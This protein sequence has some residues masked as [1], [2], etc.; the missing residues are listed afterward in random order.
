MP[1]SPIGCQ[2][3]PACTGMVRCAT[4]P[5]ASPASPSARSRPARTTSTSSPCRVPARTG[6][7]RT[8]RRSSTGACTRRSSSTDPR[9]PLAYDDEWT[10]VL[11][12]WLDGVAGS[13]DEVLAELRQG[14]AQMMAE[15]GH[16][17]MGARSA[18]FW[19]SERSTCTDLFTMSNSTMLG[20]TFVHCVLAVSHIAF[21][22][23]RRRFHRRLRSR[24]GARDQPRSGRGP[25]RVF[26]AE[27][28]G[29]RTRRPYEKTTLRHSVRGCPGGCHGR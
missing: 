8:W 24:R 20:R 10:L 15:R 14:M 5:T 9:E 11:D 23:N 27:L 19:Y 28:L 26:P 16:M 6:S 3:T 4:T 25:L 29:E 18:T 2:Q 13:P 7:T 21:D 17:M 22:R 12:D 1:P